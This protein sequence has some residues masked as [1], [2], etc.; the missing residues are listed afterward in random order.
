M[1]GGTVKAES[2]GDGRGATFTVTLSLVSTESRA[3]KL[4]RGKERS[5]GGPKVL[6]GVRV[7]VVDDDPD[8]CELLELALHDSGAEVHAVHSVRA[9]ISEL[10]SFH[11]DLLLSDIGMPDED[12]YALIR[13]MRAQEAAGGGHVPAIALTAFASHADREEALALGFDVH[14][15]KPANAD[16]L[17]RTMANLVRRAA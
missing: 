4:E 3:V 17:A 5:T 8:A 1:H 10:A 14:L 12:G 9:A 13:E 15:A 7:L 6:E 16:D 2:P 11:P